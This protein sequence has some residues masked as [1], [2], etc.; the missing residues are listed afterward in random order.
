VPIQFGAPEA[1]ASWAHGLRL[2]TLQRERVYSSE[3]FTVKKRKEEVQQAGGA[4]VDWNEGTSPAGVRG[5]ESSSRA[6]I[7]AAEIA[8]GAGAGYAHWHIVTPR[9]QP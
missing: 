1:P 3:K 7:L 8:V 6:L 4:R 2:G 5:S 9:Q